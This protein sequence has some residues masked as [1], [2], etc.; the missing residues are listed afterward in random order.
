MRIIKTDTL[1]LG[2]GSARTQTRHHSCD[3]PPRGCA[4]AASRFHKLVINLSCIAA[5][6]PIPRA[7][8]VRRHAGRSLS[9]A[10][11]HSSIQQG[12]ACRAVLGFVCQRDSIRYR[13]YFISTAPTT[14]SPIYTNHKRDTQQKIK[15]LSR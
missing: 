1:I 2:A 13:A 8:I 11:R 4:C 5:G 10:I 12:C 14:T 15:P 9:R 6:L 3:R 7:E